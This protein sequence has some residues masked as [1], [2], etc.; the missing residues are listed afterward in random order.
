V[1]R[2]DRHNKRESAKKPMEGVEWIEIE[3]RIESFDNAFI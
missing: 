3:R 2:W 1:N